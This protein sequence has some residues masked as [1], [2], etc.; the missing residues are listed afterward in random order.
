MVHH[1]KSKLFEVT[2][3]KKKDEEGQDNPLEDW[4]KGK[5]YIILVK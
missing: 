1:K 2:R 4:L 5:G 3:R